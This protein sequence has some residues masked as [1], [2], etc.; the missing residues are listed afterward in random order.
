M[1]AGAALATALEALRTSPATAG[2]VQ[3][4][5]TLPERPGI[6]AAPPPW[7][8]QRLVQALARRGIDRLYQHQADALE[9]VH[10]GRSVVVVTPTASGKTLCYNLPI[11][12][13]ITA[14][15]EARALYLF[16]TKAL[17]QDQMHEVHD[18]ITAVGLD[19]KTFTY[20]GDTPTTARRAVRAAGHIVVTNPDMLHTGILPHHTKWVKLFENLAFVVID[21]VHNYR[22]VF[23]SHVANV[24]RRLRRIAAFYGADPIFICSSATIANPRELASGITGRDMVLIDRNGAPAGQKHFVFYNPPVVNQ[25]LGI[26]RSSVLE[27]TRIAETFLS[28]EVPTIVFARSRV[29]TEVL[30]SYLKEAL[31]EPA[32]RESV[33]RAA[34]VRGYRGGYL[35]AQRREIEQ[36]LRRG[37]VL[38]V[39]ST[40][41]LELGV[42]IGSLEAAVLTGYP[43]S[44]ASTWQQAGRAGRRSGESAVCL[45]ASSAPL[46]QFMVGNPHYFLERSPEHG[47][48]DPD[49]LHIRGLHL[50]CAAF[51]LPFADGETYGQED[52]VPTARL[53]GELEGA[54]ILRHTGGRWHW[55]A[56]AFPAENVSL[57]LAETTNFVVID[58]TQPKPRVIAEVDRFSAPMLI[59]EGAIYLHEGRQFHVDRLDWEEQKAYCREVDVEHYTDA[60]LA[61]QVKV[62][63]VFDQSGPPPGARGHHPGAARLPRYLGE[64]SL[65]AVATVYKKIRFHTHENIGWGRINL[66]EQTLHTEALWFTLPPE[67]TAGL[68]NEE[69]QAGLVGL[70]TL[71][72]NVAPLYLMCDARDVRSFTEVR[73]PFTL[74][75]TVYIYD[76][77]PGGIGLVRRL[78]DLAGEVL[79]GA[80]R[81]LSGCACAEGC[82]S[83]VGPAAEVGPAKG[84]TLRFL[85]AARSAEPGP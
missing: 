10:A 5:V 83:C 49:N 74:L 76:R 28:R 32:G 20:D 72:A 73:S 34:R 15:P 33:G 18:L 52:R 55:S 62:L 24:I 82:P 84:P 9:A 14:R 53:L 38:G 16:P 41:A 17:A 58:T 12:H 56:E 77:Y 45:V 64:V 31:K 66:P 51:E 13:E 27:A 30:L 40:N 19:I 1:P 44:V 21:E 7:L 81:L 4:W 6:Y 8:D 29:T 80:E 50:K 71:M 46:D 60:N 48:I 79:E 37:E 68:S 63:E 67:V 59:H 75:P 54:G 2:C 69:V 70:G 23:G 85:R 35:P 25:E 65:S 61:V 3:H 11:L 47:L 78:F 42:D 22:G 39:V 26:R 36:G 57:R 43:G